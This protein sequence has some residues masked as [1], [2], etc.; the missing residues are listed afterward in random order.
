MLTVIEQSGKDKYGKI[1]WRCKCDCGN[2]TITHG[3]DLVNGHCKSC[4]C[5]NAKIKR[6]KSKYKGFNNSRILSI[7]KGMVYRC[8]SP[9]NSSFKDYGGRGIKVCDEWIGEQGF[10]TF[11]RWAIENGY[12]EKLTIDR[13]DNNGNYEPSNCRW[14]DWN[15]QANNRRRP[16][17]I[18]NQYGKWDYKK[19][20]HHHTSQATERKDNMSEQHR[21]KEE[22]IDAY[23]H[24]Y[25]EDNKEEAKNHE[26]VKEVCETLKEE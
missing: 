23:A 12:N 17:K 9:K 1:L 11:L 26:I 20:S 21:T 3:R 4:G 2:E 8:S 5:I 22:Y 24:Q 13:I 7:W 6:E 25:C 18:T 16:E 14:V 10:F 15:V 19:H